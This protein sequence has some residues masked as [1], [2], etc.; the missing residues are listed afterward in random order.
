MGLCNCHLTVERILKSEKAEKHWS[1]SGQGL[2]P[3]LDPQALTS[4][5][6][7]IISPY[8]T[9]KL[10]C[11]ISPQLVYKNICKEPQPLGTRQFGDWS[12]QFEWVDLGH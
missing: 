11:Q 6:R 9:K 1:K 4:V 3:G 8:R 10:A 7:G 2:L 12:P 5:T